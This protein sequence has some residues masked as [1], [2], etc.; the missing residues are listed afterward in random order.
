MKSQVQLAEAAS[1]A[2]QKY[3]VA[4]VITPMTT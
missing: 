2:R 4:G 1:L 3:I